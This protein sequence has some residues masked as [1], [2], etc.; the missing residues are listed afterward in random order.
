MS[1]AL[2]AKGARADASLRLG[3]ILVASLI[4]AAAL[5]LAWT[6]YPPAALD[7]PHKLQAP[8]G[9]HW[10]GTDALGR[11][12]ASQILAGAR[13]AC[14]PRAPRASSRTRS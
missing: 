1:L 7:I 2:G 8:S 9:A 3:V 12:V 11:D 4:F 10:L 6:P 5:S 14:S 13:S